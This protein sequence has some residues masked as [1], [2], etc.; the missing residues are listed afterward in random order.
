MP[1][2]DHFSWGHTIWCGPTDHADKHFFCERGLV[3]TRTFVCSGLMIGGQDDWRVY[4]GIKGIREYTG[5]TKYTGCTRVSR[6]YKGI[7]G[8]KEYTRVY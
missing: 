2:G 3:E 1:A 4:R 5:C 7:Q 8:V 6:V